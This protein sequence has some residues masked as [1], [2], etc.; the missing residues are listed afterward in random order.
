MSLSAAPVCVNTD[1]RETVLSDN[2]FLK[3]VES[4]LE[5]ESERRERLGETEGGDM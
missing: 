1:C 3:I 4:F 2:V 5:S